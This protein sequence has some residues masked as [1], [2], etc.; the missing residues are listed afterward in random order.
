MAAL[1]RGRSGHGWVCAFAGDPHSSDGGKW[2][3]RPYADSEAARAWVD[4]QAGVNT[5]FAVAELKD[6]DGGRGRGKKYFA[7]LSA[8]VV[9]DVDDDAVIGTP[10][11][12]LITSPGKCQVG[13]FIDPADPDARDPVVVDAIQHELYLRKLLGDNSGNNSVRYVRLPQGV[14]GK[15]RDTGPFQTQMVIWNPDQ[16]M[17][18][19]DACAVFGLDL[20]TIKARPKTAAVADDVDDVEAAD[21]VA[22]I[23]SGENLHESTIRLAARLVASGMAG[24]AVV[25]HIRSLYAASIAP[26]DD[27]FAARYHD[28]ARA[29]STAQEKFR[30]P[31]PPPLAEPGEVQQ[32]KPLLVR[33]TDDLD[34]DEPTRWL[35]QDWLEEEGLS[36]LYGPPGSGK[37]FV[38]YDFACCVATG[39][40]W[41][42][43]KVRQGPVVI[44]VGEGHRGI[45]KRLRAWQLGTGISLK[46][47][48][49]V[50]TTAAVPML[51]PSKVGVLV[52]A[53]DGAIAKMDG[54]FP[55]LVIVDTLARNFGDGDENKAEDA[56]RFI[57]AVD[58]YLRDRYHAHCLVVHHSG[59]VGGRAR[60]STAFRGAVDQEVEVSMQRVAGMKI[61]KVE[62]KKMKEDDM[63]PPLEFRL[64][65]I[66]LGRNADEEATW[67][68]YLKIA[69]SELD[70]VIYASDKGDIRLGQVLRLQEA[71]LAPSSAAIKDA[72]DLAGKAAPTAI[73]RRL[74]EGG[75]VVA[76]PNRTARKRLSEKA[77]TLL[78]E[79]G[80]LIG[81]SAT[82]A[83]DDDDEDDGDDQE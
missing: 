51:D 11:W 50:V 29:V 38:A 54:Q 30:V 22:G 71:G 55:A 28:I 18:L 52:A 17:S 58:T 37:S 25:N 15:P 47:R 16:V 12:K 46:G 80:L 67:G 68:A 44:V 40:P 34:S 3:G 79:K 24:G 32:E 23:V 66:V 53:I 69:T 1:L 64:E 49:I 73:F 26:R 81:T 65:K 74:E 82:E 83:V 33:V 19:A 10:S 45:K 7:G 61:V 76:G 13:V 57:A 2:Y 4:D 6:V 31:A 62:C 60:G 59:V 48:D 8:L 77:M 5:Y 27:R 63:P 35:V 72:F 41:N 75:W 20:D 42:G 14:N 43:K 56:N 78:S 9:D 21:A 36:M 39:T 70:E